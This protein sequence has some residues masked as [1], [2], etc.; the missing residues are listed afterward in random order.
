MVAHRNQRRFHFR[1]GGRLFWVWPYRLW[2]GCVDTLK[3]FKPDTLVRWHRR[4]YRFYWTWRS[5]S[6]RGGRPSIPRD[7]RDLIRR[8]SQDYALWGA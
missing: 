8:I 5:R 1:Q 6:C 2:P 3:I 7:V 4:G